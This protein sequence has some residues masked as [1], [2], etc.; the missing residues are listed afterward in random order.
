MILVLVFVI[1]LLDGDH[2]ME[3][4]EDLEVECSEPEDPEATTFD[5]EYSDPSH[6]T[7]TTN[8]EKK[9]TSSKSKR[10]CVFNQEWLRDPKYTQFLR[11][12]HSNKHFAHCSICKSAFS[13]ANGGTYLINRHIEQPGHKR[14]AEIQ[15]KEQCKV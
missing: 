2:P 11:K 1:N 10:K 9:T 13:I 6:R 3:L 5:E 14:L 4:N 7:T 12:C 15:S 8:T